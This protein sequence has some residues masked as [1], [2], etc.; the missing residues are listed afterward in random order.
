MS[1]DTNNILLTYIFLY[2]VN[3]IIKLLITHLILTAAT[4]LGDVG[5]VSFASLQLTVLNKPVEGLQDK[6]RN[7]VQNFQFYIKENGTEFFYSGSR[8]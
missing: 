5:H 2:N 6:L 8:A 7:R 1:K 4:C 3:Y